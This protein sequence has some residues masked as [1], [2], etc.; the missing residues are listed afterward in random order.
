VTVPAGTFE[1]YK[2]EISS[3]D[4]PDKETIWIARDSH[5]AVKES[6]ILASMGGAVLTEELM[7]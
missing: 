2:V 3:T 1:T 6:A 4:G 5:K 7:P